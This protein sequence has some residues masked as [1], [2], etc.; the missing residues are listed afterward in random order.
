MVDKKHPKQGWKRKTLSVPKAAWEYVFIDFILTDNLM[1]T[2][3][4][5]CK[6][7]Q[8]SNLTKSR[9]K[10]KKQIHPQWAGR[11]KYSNL[12]SLS[13]QNSTINIIFFRKVPWNRQEVNKPIKLC[14]AHFLGG[15]DHE[16]LLYCFFSWMIS[17]EGGAALTSIFCCHFLEQSTQFM[18]AWVSFKSADVSQPCFFWFLSLIQGV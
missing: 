17:R 8:I 13:Q 12:L 11:V 10:K 2:Y 9:T 16:S 14:L 6:M 3:W 5:Q 4:L 15:Y 1:I 18:G 7:S